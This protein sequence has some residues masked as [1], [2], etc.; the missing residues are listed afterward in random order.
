MVSVMFSAFVALPKAYAIYVFTGAFKSAVIHIY[1]QNL[2][3]YPHLIIIRYLVLK[4]AID[5][6]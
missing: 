1:P 4:N 2:Y 6:T 3:V 5:K